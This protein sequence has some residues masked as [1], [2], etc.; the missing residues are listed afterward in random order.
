MPIV[1]STPANF[2]IFQFTPVRDRA[3]QGS[4]FLSPF[5]EMVPL[6][7]NNLTDDELKKEAKNESKNDAISAIIKAAKCLV[8]RVPHQEEMIKNLE[9][10]RLK[11][12]LRLLQ[13]SSFNGKMNAL[14]EVNKVISSVSY[15]QHRNTIV[16][17]EEW[18]TAERMAVSCPRING[19]IF[20][21]AQ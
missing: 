9:I 3:V 2:R 7:L 6:I 17:E 4:M 12:I 14:N 10:L 13:I 19:D 15:H 5:Q 18:L 1:V 21:N 11:M 20:P 8:S 16:E